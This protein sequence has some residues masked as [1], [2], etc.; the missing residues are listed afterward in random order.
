MEHSEG[1]T[2][3]SSNTN[4][5]IGNYELGQT[6]GK[7][8]FSTVKLARCL[9]TGDN[10]AI[11]VFG[12]YTILANQPKNELRKVLFLSYSFIFT[13]FHSSIPCILTSYFML[14]NV[15]QLERNLLIMKMVRHPNV[16]HVIEVRW[17]NRVLH[18]L[19]I[20]S[21]SNFP[22]QVT[23]IHACVYLGV[24]D[25]YQNTFLYCNGTCNWWGT[26]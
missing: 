3:T 6:L 21:S 20:S 2:S 16:V 17:N 4:S 1:S 26:V 14:L 19:I 12:K 24:G 22:L 18:N 25:I 9:D 7:G 11:K 8:N 10:V 15:L 5:R 23:Y 13:L